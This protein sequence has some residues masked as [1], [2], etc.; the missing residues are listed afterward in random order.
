MGVRRQSPVHNS[1]PHCAD[2]VDWRCRV[3]QRKGALQ[4]W[5][6]S[7]SQCRSVPPLRWKFAFRRIGRSRTRT[8]P[9]A[10]PS[11][12]SRP[13]PY[14]RRSRSASL[15]PCSSRRRTSLPLS[16]ISISTGLALTQHP[17]LLT[18]NSS[19]HRFLFVAIVDALVLGSCMSS[20]ATSDNLNRWRP[21][22][23]ANPT[24]VASMGVCVRRSG[25]SAIRAAVQQPPAHQE[26]SLRSNGAC[27]RNTS[28]PSQF[29]KREVRYQPFQHT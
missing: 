3:N 23:Q 25:S 29:S 15:P 14:H 8:W 26:A 2:L 22:R 9:C 17:T 12:H 6:P 13:S 20:N 18:A 19:A 28:S 7:E 1:R 16:S 24:R 5:A 21:T 11:S 4:N 10:P 27:P